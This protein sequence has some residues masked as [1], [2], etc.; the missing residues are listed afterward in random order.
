MTPMESLN[1]SRDI[2]AS[3]ERV[4]EAWTSADQI[5]RWWGGG[6]VTCPE[7]HVDLRAGGSYRI[8]NALPDG[9]VMWISGVFEEIEPP[10]RLRYTWGVE[11]VDA[12]VPPSV[13]E[14]E[15]LPIDAGTRVTVNQIRIPGVPAR[16]M[17][18]MGW[19][20]CLDGLRDLLSP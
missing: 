1:I 14:V 9:S 12:E 5:V 3:P 19:N 15:F 7:A 2:G 16:D 11:P 13:V 17:F 4:F 18:E 10:Q 6:G 20:G 8:A